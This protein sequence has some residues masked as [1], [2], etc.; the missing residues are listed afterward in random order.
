MSIRIVTDSTCD[1]PP[2]F[3]AE[4][5]ITVVPAYVNF[6]TESLRDGVD[7]S[8]EAF[9]QRLP[10]SNPPPS[11]AAPSPG[12]FQ[13]AYERLADEGA[14]GIISVHLSS[15]LSNLYAAAQ[16]AAAAT[17]RVRVI[18]VDARQVSMGTGFV[19]L[20]AA[21][22]AA[23]GRALPEIAELLRNLAQRVR[24]FAVI[25]TL[26]YLRRSGRV[27]SLTAGLSSLLQI[28]LVLKIEDGQITTERV[29][30]R[31][32]A[33]QRLVDMLREQLP[34]DQIAV[35]HTAARER[36][37]EW[38]AE[39]RHLL[40]AGEIPVVEATPAIGVHVGPGAVGFACVPGGQSA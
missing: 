37:E 8:R 19:A 12:Q 33:M 26:E 34:T 13:E 39:V 32:Q 7:I 29:R 17:E 28:K 3:V 38:L 5:H 6:Q 40:P 24:V 18:A 20:A 35:L 11:T 9:Y 21:H 4:H 36:A 27:N 15:T 25:D 2:E 10:S 22:A 30:T 1:L 23:A 31:G 14:T 16:L